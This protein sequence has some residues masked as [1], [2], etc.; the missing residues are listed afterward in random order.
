M[1]EKDLESSQESILDFEEAKDLT[2]GQ[3]KRKNEEVEAG[4]TDEDS[5]LDKYIKQ[6]REEIEAGKF[7]T[8]NFE[9]I[10]EEAHPLHVPILKIHSSNIAF[11]LRIA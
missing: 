6:H 5:I 2:V 4:V 11:S 7:D 10:P 1:N 3:V 8:Q 9:K